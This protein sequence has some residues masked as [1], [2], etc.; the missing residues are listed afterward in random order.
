[1]Q[2]FDLVAMKEDS[3]GSLASRLGYKKMFCAGKE[4][5]IVEDLKSTSPRKKILRSDDFEM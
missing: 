1:M 2:F 5:E 3:L 4:V